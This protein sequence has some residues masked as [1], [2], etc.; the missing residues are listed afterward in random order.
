MNLYSI[1]GIIYLLF[2][3]PQNHIAYGNKISGAIEVCNY[4]RHIWYKYHYETKTV[5]RW[6]FF[7]RKIAFDLKYISSMFTTLK[8]LYKCN[9][10]AF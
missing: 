4:F 3:Y 6:L 10:W 2:L 8:P 1:S 9:V 7:F 5:N